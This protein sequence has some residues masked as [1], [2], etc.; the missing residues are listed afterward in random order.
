[1]KKLIKLHLRNIYHNKLFYVCLGISIFMSTIMTVIFSMITKST[2][3]TTV[4][5][6]FKSFLSSEVGLISMLFITLF[7]TF[8]FTE[9][10][11]KN[12]IA[13]GYSK[14]KL[15]LSKY[16]ASLIGLFS[17][18]AIMFLVIFIFFIKNGLG[19]ESNIPLI[20][21]FTLFKV[22]AYTVLYGTISFVLEKNSSAI[23]AN[24][25]LPNIINLILSIADSNLDIKISKYWIEN[26]GSKF[27]NTPTLSNIS[28]PLI[29]YTIYIVFFVFIGYRIVKE[30]E[31][32]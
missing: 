7:C 18:Y 13:R 26:I 10:T 32:K 11:T 31:I 14:T 15:L 3:Q 9:G 28:S 1:M 24:L 5:S 21:I 8:D 20:L 2:N 6:E 12:I 27:I 25:F 22:T 23:I 17:M 29:I 30:K 4:F 19:F 16:I